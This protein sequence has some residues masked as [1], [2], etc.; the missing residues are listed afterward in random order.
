MRL[1]SVLGSLAL[2]A[3]AF[4]FFYRIWGLLPF[5]AQVSV[6]V[7]APLLGV[8]IASLVSARDRSGHFTSMAAA[9]AFAAFVADLQ[10]LG[11]VVNAPPTPAAF[12]AWGAFALALAYGYR[13]RLPLAAGLA[14]LGAFA[15][16]IPSTALGLDWLEFMGRPEGAIPLG[17][18]VFAAPAFGVARRYQPFASIYRLIGAVFVLWPM[19]LLSLAGAGSL[20]PVLPSSA[21]LLYQWLGPIIAAGVVALGVRRRYRETV[22]CGFAF[23]VAHLYLRCFDWWWS[24]MPRYVFFLVL[25]A[26]AVALLRVLKRLRSMTMGWE[27]VARP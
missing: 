23:C 18:A 1:V 24:S 16:A 27:E 22:H 19:L 26:L 7:G 25:A 2:A 5:P 21:A 12:L 8:A 11:A 20:L 9:F 13:L 14:C 10:V 17:V 4:Y 15:A 6:L 3:S